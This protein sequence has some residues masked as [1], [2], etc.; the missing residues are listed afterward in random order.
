MEQGTLGKIR[1]AQWKRQ[2]ESEK[3][4]IEEEKEKNKNNILTIYSSETLSA[5]GPLSP[6]T[7]SKVTL[8]PLFKTT[9]GFMPDWCTK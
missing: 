3:T 2:D 8:S 1:Q 4:I 6:W 7:T 9:P 5:L